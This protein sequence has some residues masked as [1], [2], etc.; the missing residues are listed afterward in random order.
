MINS[1]SSERCILYSTLAERNRKTHLT[2]PYNIHRTHMQKSRT[3]N[4]GL[5]LSVLRGFH[6]YCTSYIH[7]GIVYFMTCSL[8]WQNYGRIP[9][10]KRRGL[11]V[12][13]C[14]LESLHKQLKKHRAPLALLTELQTALDLITACL[15]SAP[16]HKH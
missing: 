8:L 7:V 9:D 12:A 16:S 10:Q 3:L 2:K 11:E 1:V 14:K 13:Q 6:E 5:L 15:E 4:S